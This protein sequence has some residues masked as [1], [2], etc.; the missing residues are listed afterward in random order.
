[1]R[2]L[3]LY[4]IL[5]LKRAK[6]LLIFFLFVSFLHAKVL[7]TLYPIVHIKKSDILLKDIAKIDTTQN[8]LKK[9]IENIKIKK[10]DQILTKITK[11]DVKKSLKDNYIDL[12]NVNINGSD[13]VIVKRDTSKLTEANI[14]K[15]IKR[16]LSKKYGKNIE[17]DDIGLS[18]KE[19]VIPEGKITKEIYQ[20][21][22]TSNNIYLNYDIFINGEKYLS[23]PIT[24]R[25][26]FFKLAPFAKID[27]PKGKII[28]LNDIDFKRYKVSGSKEFL[29][30]EDIIGKVAKVNIKKD[31]LIKRYYLMPDFQVFKRKN[32]KIIYSNGALK[33]ELLGLALDNG[34]IG[35]IVRVKNI[36]TNKV[37]KCKVVGPFTVK[38]I[39]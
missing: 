29:T 20:R 34:T 32:V 31:R 21:S 9:F 18:K 38:Y 16:F 12:K 1:M 27:I 14:E 4:Q 30:K 13:G 7:I 15:D 19:I 33:I 10:I 11:D 22:K 36:S 28:Y 37:I 35:D 25:V 24:V 2:C 8:R 17:I 3:D 39:D 5:N 6:A 26:R 23:L